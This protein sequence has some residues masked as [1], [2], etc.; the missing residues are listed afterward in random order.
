MQK[1][2]HQN[3]LDRKR[4]PPRPFG[5][6]LEIH[7]FLKL[8]ASLNITIDQDNMCNVDSLRLLQSPLPLPMPRALLWKN[9]QHL[10]DD[11]HIE[12]RAQ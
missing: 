9:S 6:F 1:K 10:I 8:R 5:I 2:L 12:I 11:L 7:P 4:P 3:F